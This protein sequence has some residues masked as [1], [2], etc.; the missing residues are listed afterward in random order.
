MLCAGTTTGEHCGGYSKMSAYVIEDDLVVGPG[1]IGCY[2]DDKDARAMDAEGK[3]V[4]KDMTNEVSV[5]VRAFITL[6]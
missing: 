6:P 3:Y 5:C 1:Y 4:A 2:E